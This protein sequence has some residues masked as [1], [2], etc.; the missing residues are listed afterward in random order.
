[1]KNLK[2]R[3]EAVE[4]VVIKYFNFQFFFYHHH[5]YQPSNTNNNKNNNVNRRQ[6]KKQFW[7]VKDVARVL[8]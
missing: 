5:A 8:T 7:Q 4:G 2:K 6:G 1:M 3:N